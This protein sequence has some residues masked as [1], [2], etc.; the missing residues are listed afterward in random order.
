[1]LNGTFPV[2]LEFEDKSEGQMIITNIQGD[3]KQMY[4]GY[5]KG[6]ETSPATIMLF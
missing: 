6:Q 2:V 1:M 4:V 5:I 3:A